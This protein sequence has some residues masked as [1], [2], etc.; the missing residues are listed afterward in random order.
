MAPKI[1]N[2][3]GLKLECSHYVP[4]RTS[5]SN[6][7]PCVIYLHGNSGSR[8][9]ADDF[10]ESFLEKGMSVFSMDLSGCG[11][12]DGDYV[13]SFLGAN[14]CQTQNCIN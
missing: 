12:S 4:R 6:I 3:I 13:V 7:A 5:G 14:R 9:D 11:K 2:K 8:V 1:V 10:V